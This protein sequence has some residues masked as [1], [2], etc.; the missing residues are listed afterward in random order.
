MTI[1]IDGSE[2]TC[3]KVGAPKLDA[4]LLLTALGVKIN[5]GASATRL[6]GSLLGFVGP[7]TI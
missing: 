2:G 5:A 4:D 1:T 7:A 6:R 3:F